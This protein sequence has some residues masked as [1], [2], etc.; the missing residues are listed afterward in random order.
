MDDWLDANLG[1]LALT[2]EVSRPTRSLRDLRRLL[3]PFWWLNPREADAAIDNVVP[4]VGALLRDALDRGV[5][6][7][8]PQAPPHLEQPPAALFADAAE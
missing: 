1:T 4:G 3:N 8:A 2:V 6:R 5:G 7:A